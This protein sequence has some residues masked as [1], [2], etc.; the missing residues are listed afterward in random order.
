MQQIFTQY[1]TPTP[2]ELLK[3]SS[4]QNKLLTVMVLTL[5]QERKII[6]KKVNTSRICGLCVC[7]LNPQQIEHNQEKKKKNL[8]LC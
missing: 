5:Q 4:E 7:G 1:V 2:T 6:N 3:C 8:H